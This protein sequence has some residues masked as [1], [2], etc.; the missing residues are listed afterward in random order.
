MKS[1]Q[2]ILGYFHKCGDDDHY[3]AQIKSF[4]PA[5]ECE[6]L[7]R[8]EN[9]MIVAYLTDLGE[10]DF[11]K[12]WTDELPNIPENLRPAFF[13]SVVSLGDP[14]EWAEKWIGK[15][16]LKLSELLKIKSGQ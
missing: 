11:E 9:T 12:M 2:L 16:P 6:E 13:D 5:C 15:F 14:V 10:E 7:L 4:G 1:K 3:F 8:T